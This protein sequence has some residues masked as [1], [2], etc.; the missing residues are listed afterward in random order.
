MALNNK[1]AAERT[2]KFLEEYEPY[3]CLWDAHSTSCKNG[4][5]GEN[6]YQKLSQLMDI[7]DFGR[8]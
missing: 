7:E 2:I 6:V 5:E 1:W 8:A 4:V 3:S